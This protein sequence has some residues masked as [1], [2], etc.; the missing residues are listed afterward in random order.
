MVLV[1]LYAL[2]QGE[3]LLLVCRDV[4]GMGSFNSASVVFFFFFNL[5][6]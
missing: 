1:T 6:F 4:V 2:L 5:S 3:S